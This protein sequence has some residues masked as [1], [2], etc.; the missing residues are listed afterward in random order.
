MIRLPKKEYRRAFNVMLRG[1]A[2]DYYYTYLARVPLTWPNLYDIVK[3]H[4]ET[5]EVT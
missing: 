4:F 1:K 3:S 2:R 5:V